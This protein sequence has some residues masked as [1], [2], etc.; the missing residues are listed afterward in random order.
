MQLFISTFIPIFTSSVNTCSEINALFIALPKVMATL[1]SKLTI[2]HEH[3]LWG[4]RPNVKLAKSI[5]SFMSSGNLT[6][7]KLDSIPEYC[8]EPDVLFIK[9]ITLFYYKQKKALP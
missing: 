5:Q 9:R 8:D 3:L 6:I 4:E 2:A 1:S 7:P